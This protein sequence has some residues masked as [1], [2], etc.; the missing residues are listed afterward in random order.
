MLCYVCT[1]ANYYQMLLS[2]KNKEGAFIA[3]GFINWK[4]TTESERR[5]AQNEQ[6]G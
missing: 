3:S 6:G 2:N 5:L 4:N 1:H